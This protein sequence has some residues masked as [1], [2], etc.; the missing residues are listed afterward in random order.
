MHVRNIGWHED[1]A[2]I[3]RSPCTLL[4]L[5]R[6]LRGWEFEKLGME[7]RLCGAEKLV[8]ERLIVERLMWL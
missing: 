6:A 4:I 2:T 8:V 5:Y 7:K 3:E 1:F